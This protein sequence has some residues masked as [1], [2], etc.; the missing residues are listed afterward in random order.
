MVG[1]LWIRH[2]LH[3]SFADDFNHIAGELQFEALRC[4]TVPPGPPLPF[5]VQVCP[6]PTTATTGVLRGPGPFTG[7]RLGLDDPE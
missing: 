3:F 2:R 5:D 4:E 1:Y 6:G 7:V